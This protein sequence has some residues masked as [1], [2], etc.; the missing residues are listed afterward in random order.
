MEAEFHFVNE[1]FDTKLVEAHD[2]SSTQT[3]LGSKLKQLVHKIWCGGI[4]TS[5]ASFL[6]ANISRHPEL[7]FRLEVTRLLLLN[8]A[9]FPEFL[10]VSIENIC[11]LIEQN[12]NEAAFVTE[13]QK[14]ARNII[15][16]DALDSSTPPMIVNFAKLGAQDLSSVTSAVILS[17]LRN[18][19][20]RRGD[21]DI[22]PRCDI[23]ILSLSLGDLNAS[24]LSQGASLTVM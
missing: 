14:C 17:S 10:S 24:L 22:P 7:D 13:L 18:L 19:L 21:H 3:S 16:A 4:I 5:N 9:V 2:F 15:S 11:Q 12:V 8:A 1:I 23:P 6:C 20:S